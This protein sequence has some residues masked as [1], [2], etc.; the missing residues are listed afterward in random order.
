M[1]GGQGSFTLGF[2]PVAVRVVG[3]V[4]VVVRV[5]VV[6]CCARATSALKAKTAATMAGIA[7]R[8]CI[9][10][11]P[12]CTYLHRPEAQRRRARFRLDRGHARLDLRQ[13]GGRVHSQAK[14]A[15]AGIRDMQKP[16]VPTPLNRLR[17][18]SLMLPPW[19]MQQPL[20]TGMAGLDAH[21]GRPRRCWST[22][23]DRRHRRPSQGDVALPSDTVGASVLTPCQNR[24]LSTGAAE[25]GTIHGARDGARD[26]GRDVFVLCGGLPALRLR[27]RQVPAHRARAQS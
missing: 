14:R 21:P 10:S 16:P 19:P 22:R 9:W 24:S 18:P 2:V 8:L 6:R 11:S 15:E 13:L 26:G 20:D 1:P 17:K 4:L 25:P 7:M 12:Y 23:P 3:A 5:V 27:L